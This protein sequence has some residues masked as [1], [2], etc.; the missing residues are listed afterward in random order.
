M[1]IVMTWLSFLRHKLQVLYFIW[2]M[3][4]SPETKIDNRKMT[5]GLWNVEWSLVE[6]VECDKVAVVFS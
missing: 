3:V 2:R 6:R 5:A 1:L 4:S